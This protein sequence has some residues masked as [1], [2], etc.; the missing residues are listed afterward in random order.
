[1]TNDHSEDHRWTGGFLDLLIE[2]GVEFFPYVPDEAIWRFLQLAKADERTSTV[3]LTTEEEG[4]SICAGLDLVGRR[5]ALVMQSSGL[6]NCV[7]FLSIT[8]S[9]RSPVLMILG[10]RGEYGESNPWQYPMGQAVL[11]VLNAVGVIP[12]VISNDDDIPLATNAAANAVFKGRRSA[13]IILS[14]KFLGAKN[15]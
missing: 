4:V 3:L 14:Q 10:M 9:A 12:Y 13:A 11:P 5:S 1:M 15:L 8:Q 2:N 6:G 7:N